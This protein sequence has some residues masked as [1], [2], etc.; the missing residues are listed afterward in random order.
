[1]SRGFCFVFVNAEKPGPL[2]FNEK[3][4]GAMYGANSA[5]FRRGDT[6]AAHSFRKPRHIYCYQKAGGRNNK[7]E[8][9]FMYST[10]TGENS[11]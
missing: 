9:V 11:T 8:A 7:R 10:L 6:F 2:F 3:K 4:Q 1:M 5:W